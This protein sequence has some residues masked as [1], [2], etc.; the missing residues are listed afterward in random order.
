MDFVKHNYTKCSAMR[1]IDKHIACLGVINK[2][3]R[4]HEDEYSCC[5]E[6]TKAVTSLQQVVIDLFVCIN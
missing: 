3:L 2:E 4:Q 6:P 1:T 5:G